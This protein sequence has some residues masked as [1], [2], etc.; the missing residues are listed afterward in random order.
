MK[1]RLSVGGLNAT[2]RYAMLRLT[3]DD[4]GYIIDVVLFFLRYWYIL[5]DDDR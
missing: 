1:G 5:S 3:G 4:A 2:L